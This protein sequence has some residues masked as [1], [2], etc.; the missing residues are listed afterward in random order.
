MHYDHPQGRL[1][2]DNASLMSSSKHPC[3]D[4]VLIHIK[5]KPQ[6]HSKQYH[7]LFPHVPIGSPA[8]L[9]R[10]NNKEIPMV[11]FPVYLGIS[12]K[13]IIRAGN[14]F[15]ILVYFLIHPELPPSL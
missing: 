10:P 8:G 11:S 1:T 5:T 7:L 4:P 12:I 13:T 15:L 9:Y 14:V 3:P 2:S 6:A